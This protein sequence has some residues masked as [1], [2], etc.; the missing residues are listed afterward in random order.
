M[1]IGLCWACLGGVLI[2]PQLEFCDLE[3]VSYIVVET[4]SEFCFQGDY[5]FHRPDQLVISVSSS[6]SAEGLEGKEGWGIQW[7]SLDYQDTL[8][9]GL[10]NTMHVSTHFNTSLIRTPHTNHKSIHVY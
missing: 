8:I 3:C 5:Q 2:P 6:A 7:C 9:I 4:T 1:F 10:H